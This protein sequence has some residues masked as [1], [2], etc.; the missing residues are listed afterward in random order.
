MRYSVIAI[1][2]ELLLGQVTD[3]NSGA[4]ARMLDPYGWKL[5]NVQV[6]ADDADAIRQAID[7]AFAATDVVLTTGGLGP[8]KDDITKG[9]LTAYFGGELREDAAVLENVIS[10]MTRNGRELNDLTRAQAIV[11]TSCEVIQ[12]E[13]GTAPLMWFER[14]GKVLVSM[15]GVPHET[16]T[17]MQRSV[18]PRLLSRFPSDVALDHRVA[19][20]ADLSE[21]RVA[22]TLAEW[23]DALPPHL[24]IAYLP[25]ARLIRLRLDGKSP[26]AAA[27]S[28]E[29]D[30]EYAKMI[31]LLGNHVV[32]TEDIP[33]PEVLIKAARAKGLTIATAESCTG[34]NIAHEITAIPGCSDVMTGGIVSYSNDVKM[35]VLGVSPDTLE[36]HGAVSEQTVAEMLRGAHAACG[37]DLVMATSGIAGPGGGTPDK[38]VGTVV[39]GASLRGKAPVITTWHF[40]GNRSRII[41]Q[42]TTTALITALHL[43]QP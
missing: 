35:R 22:M 32:A 30:R 11:P 43:L 2:D 42:S 37:A 19:L 13:V 1:G 36:Q 8:T 39:I 9:V 10:V 6:V 31:A 15:P 20:V 40:G 16:L 26:D 34:G 7:R 18:L 5:D 17:M 28:E 38:P 23:E 29:L 41:D 27:L 25:K 12:N 21:S 24:H 14:G 33:L 3:T 4:I